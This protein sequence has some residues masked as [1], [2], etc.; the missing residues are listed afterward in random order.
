MTSV[1][2]NIHEFSELAAELTKKVYGYKTPNVSSLLDRL[3]NKVDEV[4]A[5]SQVM[6]GDEEEHNQ[7]SGIAKERCESRTDVNT[8]QFHHLS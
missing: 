4:L 7:I 5:V 8:F 6:I 2:H 1:M 3:R